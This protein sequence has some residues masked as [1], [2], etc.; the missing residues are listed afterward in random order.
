[1]R[2]FFLGHLGLGDH[3]IFA[4]MTHW[5][6]ENHAEELKIVC[7]KINYDTL[8][9]MYIDQPK[10]TFYPINDDNEISPSYGAPKS[11]IE[12]IQASGYKLLI[13][14]S[15]G[16]NARTYLTLDPCW[17][18]CFYKEFQID[19]IIRFSHW[20]TPL[21][22]TAAEQKWR[23]LL[24]AL[25][26]QEYI[27][28]HDDPSRNFKI[29]YTYVH[30]TLAQEDIKTLPIVYLGKD[31]YKYPLITGLNNPTHIADILTCDSVFDLIL[32]LKHARSVHM[33]DSSLAILLDMA[34]SPKEQ[35]TLHQTRVSYPK[36][37]ILPTHT[38]LYQGAWSYYEA[39]KNPYI[40]EP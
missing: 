36:Y 19:P 28:V 35:K 2:F 8:K 10:I 11:I 25:Y 20:R 40:D 14:G 12:G 34:S 15:H 37:E 17:A 27:I 3:F 29:D 31:R 4:G 18:N 38:G 22:Q 24:S 23:A 5:L 9:A 33:M 32:I 1:M 7:K 39:S 21:Q 16:Q 26:G 6:V 30:D 13:C